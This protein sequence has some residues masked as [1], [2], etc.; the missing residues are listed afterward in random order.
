MDDFNVV[1]WL[2]CVSFGITGV[3][4]QTTRAKAVQYEEPAKTAVLNYFQSVIQLLMDFAAFRTAFTVQQM[5]GVAIIFAAN[6]IKWVD[7]IKN[8]FKGKK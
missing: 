2:I 5:I 7:N 8:I 3:F 4:S 1:D 6:T